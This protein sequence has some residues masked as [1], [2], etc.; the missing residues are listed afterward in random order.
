[1]PGD[2][3]FNIEQFPPFQPALRCILSIT[4]S[5]PMVITTSFDGTTAG[6]NQYD[7]GLIVRIF[8]PRGCGML[9]ANGLYGPITKIDDNSFS[10]DFDSTYFDPYVIPAQPPALGAFGMVGQVNPI[11]EVG[12]TVQQ[13]TRN[14]LP[15]IR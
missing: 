1:M 5:N 12:N 3:R 7:T 15:I 8:I 6:D 2:P 13:A 9:Q 14:V 4:Q 11:G 10:M